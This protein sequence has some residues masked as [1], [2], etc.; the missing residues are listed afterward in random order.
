MSRSIDKHVEGRFGLP[1]ILVIILCLGTL[2]YAQADDVT[3]NG[4]KPTKEVQNPSPSKEQGTA[5]ETLKTKSSSNEESHLM[6]A[7]E[8]I[9]YN[10]Q[11]Q[12]GKVIG[13]VKDLMIRQ[14]SGSVPF[15]VVSFGGLGIKDE[16][17]FAI[18]WKG[19]SH[20]HVNSVCILSVQRVE[21][22]PFGEQEDW[23][24]LSEEGHEPDFRGE[25]GVGPYWVESTT[26]SKPIGIEGHFSEDLSANAVLGAP[27]VDESNEDLGKLS[28][29]MIDVEEGR[30]A[31]TVLHSGGILGI[32]GEK[33]SVP[34][35]ILKFTGKP[36]KI[37]VH[38]DK[39]RLKKAPQYQ[40]ADDPIYRTRQWGQKVYESFDLQP[41]W[42]SLKE[43]SE[44]TFG[45][46]VTTIENNPDLISGD[47][48][49][50]ANVVD[51]KGV[52]IGEIENIAIDPES[53]E[54]TLVLISCGGII[55]NDGRLRAAPFD[56][57]RYDQTAGA[58]RISVS[59]D[60]F[61]EAPS[62]GKAEVPKLKNSDWSERV[63]AFYQQGT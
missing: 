8:L 9:G 60:R 3:E 1:L 49:I 13:E 63:R 5:P 61:Y 33:Y 30:V 59:K 14:T 27:V 58:F 7:R 57:L 37:T 39:E 52:E 32:G 12:E 36:M 26:N 20:D 28:E 18:P 31:Y 56:A 50:G 43:W 62:F 23:V 21:K 47:H 15:V 19:L 22:I 38:V 53:G 25:Y 6:P 44:K 46:R 54:I 41:Y 11:D 48:L 51:T 4:N 45:G 2:P 40:S 34:W 42:V 17:D 24:K 10:V 55:Q 16:G 35:E 29:L